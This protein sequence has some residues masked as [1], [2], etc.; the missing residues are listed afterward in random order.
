MCKWIPVKHSDICGKD[1]IVS[2]L[3]KD[4]EAVFVTVNGTKVW[5][6]T[7]GLSPNGREIFKHFDIKNVEAW[8]NFPKPYNPNDRSSLWIPINHNPQWCLMVPNDG[9]RVLITV[10]EWFVQTDVF[11]I[12]AD[13]TFGFDY[14]PLDDV[15]AWMTFPTPYVPRICRDCRYS[16]TLHDDD[17]FR[18][19]TH[20][21]LLEEDV[22]SN[23]KPVDCPLKKEVDHGSN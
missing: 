3:P 18:W 16:M 17:G 1:V 9:E 21:Q 5:C 15:T 22:F 19:T 11:R 7:F 14:A 8:M 23:T 4:G 2:E 6:D 13:G 10:S 20:C 12:R